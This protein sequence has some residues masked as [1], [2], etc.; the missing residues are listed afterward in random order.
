[1]LVATSDAETAICYSIFLSATI[2]LL[3]D[4]SMIAACFFVWSFGSEIFC[5]LAGRMLCK[6]RKCELGTESEVVGM[7]ACLLT[8][9]V[10]VVFVF[11]ERGLAAPVSTCMARAL[12]NQ[13]DM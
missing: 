7:L 11:L 6:R 4:C 8:T 9:L 3:F 2:I 12:R 10:G 13:R 1:M 5:R